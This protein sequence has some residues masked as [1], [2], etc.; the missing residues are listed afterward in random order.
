[1][2]IQRERLYTYQD[3]Q[4]MEFGEGQRSELIN[5][6]IYLLASASTRH[7]SILGEIFRQLSNHLRG[8]KCKPFL[9][10]DVRLEKDTVLIPDLILVC[11]SRRLTKNG[12]N[13]A[14]DLAVEI[15]SPSTTR[16]DKL[17]KFQLYQQAGVPEYWIVD[18]EDNVI[19]IHRLN[20]NIYTTTVL[21]KADT[22][23]IQALPDFEM[24]LPEVF[25]DEEISQLI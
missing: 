20:G 5:G 3:W 9:N 21:N 12:C 7:Q 19:T 14:P 24:D 6:R 1:M 8:K 22:A 17:T 10:L 18:P 2:A 16:H 23:A 11:D 25:A 4:A 15:L 13:G